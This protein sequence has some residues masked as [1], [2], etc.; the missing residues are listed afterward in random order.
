MTGLI[1]IAGEEFK[2]A[3]NTSADYAFTATGAYIGM[4]GEMAVQYGGVP[5]KKIEK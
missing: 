5:G 1:K 4:F 2:I 3:D